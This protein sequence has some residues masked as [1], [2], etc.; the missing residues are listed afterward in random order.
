MNKKNKNLFS[1]LRYIL[2]LA[3]IVLEFLLITGGYNKDG[4]TWLWI[5]RYMVSFMRWMAVDLFKS[6]NGI[7]LA[8]IFMTF[9]VRLFLLPIMYKQQKN[10]TI[11]SV[12]MSKLQPQLQKVQRLIKKSKSREE[13]LKINQLMMSVYKKNNVSLTGGINFL[14]LLIQLPIISGLYTAIRLSTNNFLNGA[15]FF[16][17]ALYKPSFIIAAIAGLFYAGQAWLNLKISPQIQQKQMKTM[18]WFTPLLT[19]FFAIFQ[20]AALGLY[21][22]VG[23]LF[24]FVQTGILLVN[25]AKIQRNISFNFQVKDVV[26]DFLKKQ[27]KENS[28]RNVRTNL[29]RNP[30]SIPQYSNNMIRYRNKGKQRRKPRL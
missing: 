11:Q 29:K 24:V 16:G 19:F 27:N 30:Q 12:K 1:Y 8:I 7:G 20:S 15:H 25:R 23:G 22:V 9:V 2:V 6:T 3:L 21:F 5:S 10:G 14:S 28:S 4:R 13:Q 26:S 18:I 17:I